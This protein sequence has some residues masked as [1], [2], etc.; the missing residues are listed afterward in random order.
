MAGV[1]RG[2]CSLG[3]VDGHRDERVFHEEDRR[4]L[5]VVDEITPL[6]VSGWRRRGDS[7][8]FAVAMSISRLLAQGRL[9][10]TGGSRLRYL[11]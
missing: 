8:Q 3:L 6:T 4:L 11:E 5:R 1:P 10:R 2:R 7:I 9:E